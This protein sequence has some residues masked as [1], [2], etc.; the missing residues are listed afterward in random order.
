[1]SDDRVPPGVPSPQTS[2]QLEDD[3]SQPAG[4][5]FLIEDAPPPP[6]GEQLFRQA[7]EPQTPPPPPSMAPIMSSYS[8]EQTLHRPD[9]AGNAIMLRVIGIIAVLI[10]PFLAVS[11]VSRGGLVVAAA[12]FLGG[13]FFIFYL[14]SV[15]RLR[16]DQVVDRW[17]ILLDGAQGRRAQVTSGMLDRVDAHDVPAI[18]YE[19]RDLA[20]SFIRAETREF[21]VVTHDGNRRLTGYRMH[22][23]VRDYGTCLQASWYLSYHRGFFEKMLPNPIVTLDLFDEQDLR[24]YV[25]V[26]HRAFLD[27]IVDLMVELGQDTS[28]LER[29]SKGFLGIS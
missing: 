4:S 27:A 10:A 24:A 19:T 8:P 16:R 1:M 29:S 20:T 15:E 7:V 6:D 25:G 14:G 13:L 17:D 9:P 23:N 26:V 2:D 28:K 11:A 5:G 3:A 21:V 12:L 22:V 18:E